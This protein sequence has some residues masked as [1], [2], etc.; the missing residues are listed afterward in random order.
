MGFSIPK[1]GYNGKVNQVTLGTGDKTVTFGGGDA[2]PFHAFDG[3]AGCNFPIAFEVLDGADMICLRLL[4]VHPDGTN[5]SPEEAGKTVEAILKA[6]DVPLIIFGANS[7]E[8]DAD[9]IKHVAEVAA[10]KNCLI[11]KAQEKNYKTI[12]AAAM[13]YDH[14]LLALSNLDINLAKQ[15]NILLGQVGVPQEKIVID[16]MGAALGYGLEYSYSVI[17]R[18]RGAALKQNDATV[19]MPIIA[20]IGI[21][22]WKAKESKV[23]ESEQPTW[24]NAEERGI[25]W[26]VTTAISMLMAGADTFI[27][28]HPAAVAEVRKRIKDIQNCNI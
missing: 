27:M 6:I 3:G 2:Y 19:Q 11:G 10:G 23:S 4:S 15:L 22:S 25:M 13:A 28:R 9:V 7:L 8:K 14:H 26:E 20:D 12:A 24:G 21:E 16:T 18:V 17:E 5:R 1:E